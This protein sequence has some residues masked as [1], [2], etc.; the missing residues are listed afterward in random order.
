MLQG[1]LNLGKSFNQNQTNSITL[2][3]ISAFSTPTLADQQNSDSHKIANLLEKMSDSKFKMVTKRQAQVGAV[4]NRFSV[5]MKIILD[6]IWKKNIEKLIEKKYSLKHVRVFR[7]LQ[8]LEVVNENQIEESCLL[9]LKDVRHILMD[10][11]KEELIQMHEINQKKGQYAYSLII[12]KYVKKLISLLYKV[13]KI[14]LKLFD[15]L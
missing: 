14:L 11:F 3:E 13:V 2:A 4:M 12:Q 9:N 15:F 5:N 6:T 1:S 8:V 7:A 10:L